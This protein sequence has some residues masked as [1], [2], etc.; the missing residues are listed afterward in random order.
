MP[1]YFFNFDEIALLP[2]GEDLGKHQ[3]GK[4]GSLDGNW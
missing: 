2:N 3:L 1:V 4:K